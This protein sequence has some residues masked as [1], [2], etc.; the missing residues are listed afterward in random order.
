MTQVLWSSTGYVGCAEAR[1]SDSS[2]WCYATVCLY[3]KVS[4]IVTC[5]L[6]LYLRFVCLV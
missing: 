2:N 6:V 1:N 3:A 5:C 4:N